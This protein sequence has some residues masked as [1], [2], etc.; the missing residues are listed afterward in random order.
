MSDFLVHLVEMI[1]HIGS[2]GL[3]K[4]G[5]CMYGADYLGREARRSALWVFGILFVLFLIGW[6]LWRWITG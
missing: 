3:G 6:G 5:T 4:S 2:S 1:M